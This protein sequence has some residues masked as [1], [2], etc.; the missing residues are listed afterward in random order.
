LDNDWYI[1]SWYDSGLNC[2]QCC[3]PRPYLD[4]VVVRLPVRVLL[5]V[6]VVVVV[7]VVVSCEEEEDPRR[8]RLVL[9]KDAAVIADADGFLKN[10]IFYRRCT[11]ILCRIVLNDGLRYWYNGILV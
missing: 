10:G 7:V 1:N 3:P 5:A 4:K 11:A 8:R 6:A 2:L 9:A